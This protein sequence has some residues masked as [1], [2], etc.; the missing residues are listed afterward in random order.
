MRA[1]KTFI[2]ILDNASGVF[3]KFKDHDGNFKESLTS[4]ARGMLSLYE[5][6]HLRVHGEDILEEALTFTTA[7]LKSMAAPN[8]DQNLAKHINDALEQP[9]HMGV[10]RIEAHKFIPFY[11]HDDS[12]NDTLLKFAKLDFNRV[13]LPHQQE[14]A[15]I[16]R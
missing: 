3:N 5:A 11:E 14:L 9:L 12:K 13:Q 10:P 8:L 16:T 1:S 7:H 4:D 2:L 15:Y 6:T